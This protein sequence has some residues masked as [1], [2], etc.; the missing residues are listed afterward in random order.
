MMQ[1]QILYTLT[2]GT[3][4]NHY[5]KIGVLDQTLSV[6]H[7]LYLERYR[8]EYEEYFSNEF[9]VCNKNSTAQRNVGIAYYYGGNGLKKSKK[10]AAYWLKKAYHN[11]NKLAKDDLDKFKL[12]RY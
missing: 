4:A 6:L 10:M 3:A 2:S 7:H 12:W 11:G 1:G 5:E 9:S 8:V